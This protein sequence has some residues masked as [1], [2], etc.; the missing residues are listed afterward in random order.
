MIG[1]TIQQARGTRQSS[2]PAGAQGDADADAGTFAPRL[3]CPDVQTPRISL[4]Y[5]ADCPS[6]DRA[7]RNLRAALAAAGLAITWHEVCRSTAGPP[8][9]HPGSPTILVNDADVVPGSPALGGACR[10]YFAENGELSRAP[11]VDAI[12]LAIRAAAI[13]T[14]SRIRGSASRS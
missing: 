3:A 7:R 10:T 11:S 5:D 1:L 6:A 13:P 14:R 4:V 8:G 9:L 12:L 2:R